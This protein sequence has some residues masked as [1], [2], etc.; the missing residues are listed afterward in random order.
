VSGSIRK[1][2]SAQDRI[3]RSFCKVSEPARHLH[4]LVFL[5]THQ[6]KKRDLLLWDVLIL[7]QARALGRFTI[8][9][10]WSDCSGTLA[11]R[12]GAS[13]YIANFGEH[14]ST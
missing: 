6:L 11:N 5:T 3:G 10:S 8:K 9:I 1:N 2:S 14:F 12:A 13:K 4:E 7:S